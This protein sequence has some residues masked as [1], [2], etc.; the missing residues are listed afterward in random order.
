LFVLSFKRT[1]SESFVVQR[2]NRVKAFRAEEG[3]QQSAVTVLQLIK[4]GRNV[5]RSHVG[6]QLEEE[7]M[8]E[9]GLSG[10]NSVGHGPVRLQ[11]W[12][13]EED[14]R[15][16]EEETLSRLRQ[17]SFDKREKRKRR[18]RRKQREMITGQMGPTRKRRRG[19]GRGRDG[20]EG[21]G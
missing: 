1:R 9:P 5:T 12:S 14:W 10:D 15:R 7:Y 3:D 17:R 21:G 2:Y 13:R 4:E 20:E 11:S 19:R 16:Q 8:D 6:F 18:R